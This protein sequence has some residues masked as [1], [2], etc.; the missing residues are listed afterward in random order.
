MTRFAY[1]SKLNLAALAGAAFS[2][3]LFASAGVA[4]AGPVGLAAQSGNTVSA[5]V[6][7]ARYYRRYYGGPRYYGYRH[8]RRPYYPAYSY[9]YP[10]YG[11]PAYGY[12]Y[13]YGGYGYG[14]PG[15]GLGFFGW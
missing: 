10:A 3:T 6:E 5:P 15:I 9:G 13:P 8:Y 7:E 2:L 1:P 4:S 11:Y 14:R 12:G